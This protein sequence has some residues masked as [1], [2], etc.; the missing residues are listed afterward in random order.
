MQYKVPRDLAYE[1]VES[2]H[3][4]MLNLVLLVLQL[5]LFI[6]VHY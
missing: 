2:R 4:I 6:F 5:H 1:T 3:L